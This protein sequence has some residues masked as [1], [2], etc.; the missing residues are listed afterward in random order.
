MNDTFK[1]VAF[2]LLHLVTTT[3]VC[4]LMDVVGWGATILI[5]G[6]HQG[7]QMHLLIL[8]RTELCIGAEGLHQE[9]GGDQQEVGANG[10]NE[11]GH[12]HCQNRCPELISLCW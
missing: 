5:E 1:G 8:V 11:A 6:K 12:R 10:G 2:S 7:K 3:W 4:G 9:P